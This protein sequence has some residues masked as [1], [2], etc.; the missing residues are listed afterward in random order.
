M[1][2]QGCGFPEIEVDPAAIRQNV[3]VI[4][5]PQPGSQT[6][7]LTCP[8]REVLYEGTRGPGKTDALIMDYAQ[9]VGMGF[10]AA[11]RGVLFRETYPQLADVW[12]KTKKWFHQI[13]PAARPNESDYIW[14]FPDGEE[15][16]LSY[17]SKAKD[18]WNWHGH[19]LPWIG[20]E[21]LTNLAEGSF[22]FSMFSCNRSSHGDDR[23]PRH[24]RATC[25]PWG[26]GHQW[27]KMR[28]IDR[29][30]SEK[31][32]EEDMVNPVTGER[33]TLTRCYIHGHWSENKRLIDADPLYI[34]NIQQEPD[35]AKRKAWLEGDW[36]IAVGG[37]FGSYW[38][39][40]VHVIK[41]FPIPATWIVRRAFD[42][43]SSRPFSLG[44]WA[45]S[46]GTEFVAPDGRKICFPRGTRIRI[47]EWYG[48]KEGP[49][50]QPNQGLEMLAEDV[51]RGIRRRELAMKKSGFIKSDVRPGPADSSIFDKSN[52]QKNSI[53]ELMS[54]AVAIDGKI[55]PGV[56]FVEADKSPG[57]RVNGWEA[58]RNLLAASLI[59]EEGIVKGPK[60][61]PMEKPGL[62]IFDTCRHW[63]RTVPVLPRDP[64]KPDDVDTDAEDHA[65]DETRYEV[66]R[67][68]R[69]GSTS[70]L[71]I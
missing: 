14:K 50:V 45:H 37:I 46:D 8:Y 24:I 55:Y 10:G 6:R 62:F 17:G 47:N 3:R 28:F 20:F 44:W 67:K 40:S 19:E 33:I 61:G 11:W 57:S 41:P 23:M 43:G 21:E 68:L 4:W 16:K 22:Y 54:K 27:V 53:A 60:Q 42:W 59:V 48:C 9:F 5:E 39:P 36:N 26:V 2:R 52:G 31:P 32:I 34:A 12:A 56:K 58:I 18:Y 65:G 1:A 51:A 49:T 63:I 15:L 35:E 64:D 71:N 13:F 38:Q 69:R 66:Y 70:E 29:A 30:A 25:N 7:F